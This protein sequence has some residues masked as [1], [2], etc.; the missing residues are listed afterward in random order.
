VSDDKKQVRAARMLTDEGDRVW[1]FF[2]EEHTLRGEVGDSREALLRRWQ[3][4]HGK[5]HVL[6]RIVGV[7]RASELA[8]EIID[9]QSQRQTTQRT[10]SWCHTPNDITRGATLCKS[11]CHRA[12]VSRL[13]CDCPLC[14]AR[15]EQGA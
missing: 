8:M 15:K 10:C 14:Q 3:Q 4:A 1:V 11:C 6:V 5:V 12:D 13:Q 2:D 7:C 9:L